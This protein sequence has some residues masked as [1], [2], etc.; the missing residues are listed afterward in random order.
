LPTKLKL[1]NISKQNSLSIIPQS[2]TRY[3]NER[4]VSG[5]RL[6]RKNPNP[7]KELIIMF[8]T[9]LRES[10]LETNYALPLEEALSIKYDERPALNM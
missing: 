4:R 8:I 7:S 5:Q 3:S 9:G 2:T 6:D 1:Q 10:L